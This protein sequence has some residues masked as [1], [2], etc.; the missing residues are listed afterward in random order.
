MPLFRTPWRSL[1]GR[2]KAAQRL[3]ALGSSILVD[4]EVGPCIMLGRGPIG[5]YAVR[6]NPL[7]EAAA[8]RFQQASRGEGRQ[9]Q[10]CLGEEGPTPPI[11]RAHLIEERHVVAAVPVLGVGVGVGVGRDVVVTVPVHEVAHSKAPINAWPSNGWMDRPMYRPRLAEQASHTRRPWA[12]SGVA[13]RRS[14]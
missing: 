7:D 9:P 1:G 13:K 11:Q 5:V 8:R 4:V 14:G 10:R 2:R 3:E 6:E 12:S